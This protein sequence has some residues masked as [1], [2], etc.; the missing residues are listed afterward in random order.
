MGRW[1]TNNKEQGTYIYK[2]K[3]KIKIT[4]DP[5][6]LLPFHEIKISESIELDFDPKTQNIAKIPIMESFEIISNITTHYL[7]L[8]QSNR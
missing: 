7:Y 3:F 8:I 5:F 1:R 6:N 2:I 4:N